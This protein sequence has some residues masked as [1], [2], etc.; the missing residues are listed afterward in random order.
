[1]LWIFLALLVVAALVGVAVEEVSYRKRLRRRVLGQFGKIPDEGYP[2]EEIPAY[3]A[4]ETAPQM[5]A[6]TWDDL[7]MD[8]VF[9]RMNSCQSSVGEQVLY[10][11]LHR[12]E[13]LP[14]WEA[15]LEHLDKRPKER[16]ELWLLLARLGKRRNNYG[17]PSFLLAPVEVPL[18][19]GALYPLFV[20]LPLLGLVAM[21]WN[22]WVGGCV[23][24]A[25]LCWN[26]ALYYLEK[27]RIQGDLEYLRSFSSLLWVAGK[28]KRT[29]TFT[30][31]Q[32]ELEEALRCLNVLGG[33][34]AGLDRVASSDLELVQ[35][36][37]HVLT[38]RDLRLYRKACKVLETHTQEVSQLFED[39]GLVD[40]AIA[41]LSFRKSLVQW[42]RPSFG[43]ENALEFT[44]LVHPLLNHPVGNSHRLEKDVLLTGSNASGKS[45]FLKALAVNA[46]LGQSVATCAAESYCFRPGAVLTSMAVRDDITAGESYFM[47]EVRSLK[48]LVEA[49]RRGGCLL[50]I[51]EILKGTNTLERLA[52][53]QAVL[54]N[55]HARDCL[56]VAA[57]HD[58]ELT[59]RLA[60]QYHCYHFQEELTQEGIAF[61]YKLRP[62]PS[63]TRNAIRL[64][65]VLGFPRST[66]Q[67]AQELA[68][69]GEHPI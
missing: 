55:L 12:L 26:V 16:E 57:T 56:C 65:D 4:L 35:E 41:T 40:A 66:V 32:V 47:A 15:L 11:Q 28:L 23:T 58:L 59:Q 68:E 46:I 30:P 5:D 64:L 3:A 38:L 61:D 10:R 53:S 13:L 20:L 63:N 22:I 48:R 7:D 45:T 2:L 60:G 54:E 37:F 24:L 31:L 43:A 62:G 51:D 50:F 67:R 14:H 25:A 9:R 27:R 19:F 21:F 17:L 8:Q 52:A 34:L 49:A 18:L 1:M 29:L 42:C 6:T 39:V 69:K 33:R 44:C 36:Y